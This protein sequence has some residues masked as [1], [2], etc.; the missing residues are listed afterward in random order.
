VAHPGL[1]PVAMEVFDKHMPQPNQLDKLRLDVEI[2]AADL[3]KVPS[4]KITEAGLR[5]NISVGVQ[6]L[7]SWLG[8]NG[9]VPINNLMED[10]ATAEISRAQLW[11]WIKHPRGVLDDGRRVTAAL[12]ETLLTQELAAIRQEVG[13]AAYAAGNFAPAA[14]IFREITESKEFVEFITL[15]AY[16]RLA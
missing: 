11:Q 1:V 2:T 6:Y 10:A 8:G 12:F 5:N 16:A 9:C 14:E 13:Q 15:P 7:A 3:L 4:G